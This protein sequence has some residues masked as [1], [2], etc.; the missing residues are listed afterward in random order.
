[1]AAHMLVAAGFDPTVF[2]GAVPI[3]KLS[4]GRAGRWN[5]FA[6][7]NVPAQQAKIE[8]TAGAVR[9]EHAIGAA[10]QDILVVE[11]CEF[12]QN[13]LHLH[14]THAVILGIEPDH[15]DCYDSLAS[16]EKA[17][18][19]FA[20]S[21]P[22]DGLLLARHECLSTQRATSNLAHQQL[23]I[24]HLGHRHLS[25]RHLACRRETFGFD[26]DADWSAQD[27]HAECGCFQFSVWRRGKHVCEATL[28]TPGRH[29][30]L[31]ALAAIALVCHEGIPPREAAAALSTFAG[32]QRRLEVSEP[33]EGITV[34]DDYAHHPTEVSAALAAVREMFPH[35]R[36]LC[37]FQPHQVSR[38]EKLQAAFAASLQNAEKVCIANIF[39]AREASPRPGEITA[40]E[41]AAQTRA[42]GV[43]VLPGHTS[44]EIGKTLENHLVLGDVLVILG[45]GDTLP[46]R[47]H[48]LQHGI[49]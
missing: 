29:N 14:P 49:G 27:L 8:T 21:I 39:R 5:A 10:K 6:S 4:G 1:M 38:T 12:R 3:G 22:S 47:P 42:G 13:F 28:Q 26:A 17:F 34:V 7:A 2:C 46:L 11:A 9:D 43:T 44:E 48:W 37:V 16:L 20:A 15:F 25:Y 32:L 35:R 36:V 33:G 40:A 23:A 18:S 19:E 31:N 41:L 24:D 30:V 45:A